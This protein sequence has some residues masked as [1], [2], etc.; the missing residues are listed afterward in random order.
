RKLRIEDALNATKAAVDEGIVPGGGTTLIRLI[1]KI[2]DIKDGLDAEEQ[3]GAEIVAKALEAP[4]R[5]IADNAG[6]EGT[7]IVEKVRTSDVNIGYNAATDE[8]EDLIA[9]GIID[10]AKVVRSA[11]QNAGSIA[12]MVLTT[13]AL[14]VEKPEKKAA[15]P[16]MGGMG[17]MGMM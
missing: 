3:I 9:A 2:A 1:P 11:L 14:V 10:P 12:S 7:V 8:F 13:E 6:V 5:Q 17:G 16:G 15:A 4:L